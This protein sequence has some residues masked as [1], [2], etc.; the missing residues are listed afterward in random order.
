[1][2]YTGIAIG[3]EIF[4]I[5]PLI[6]VP[7][8]FLGHIILVYKRKYA[9]VEKPLVVI[10]VLFALSWV[11]SAF[12]T[13]HRGITVTP[14]YF[15][16]SSDFLFLLAANVG[17]VIMPFMLFYQV[18]AT[19]EKRTTAKS[20]WAIRLETG[21]G[22]FASEIIMVAILIAA[23]GVSAHSMNFA[24]PRIL[25]QGLSSVAGSFA[26]YVFG[27]GLIA[28][29]FIALIVISLGSSWG[30]VE[31]LGWGRKNWFKVYLVESVP[32][33]V[34]PLL[35]LNLVNLALN[36]M[37][38]QLVVLIGPAVLLGL[39]SANKK[40]MGEHSLRGLNKIT[41]W[42]F[43]ILIVSTGIVSMVLLIKNL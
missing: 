28:A 14:F 42:G 5:S 41:Y 4:G 10:S 9:E 16:T 38:L 43:L 21:I 6:S 37:V 12:L 36:L 30:V 1:V 34:L 29:S 22:A 15:S 24:A 23:V 20:L 31:A 7:V 25:A 33:V 11:V 8:V 2:E 13:A 19:A 18:S 32:A 40:L 39:I 26:P 27:I 35:S 3:F 17:A